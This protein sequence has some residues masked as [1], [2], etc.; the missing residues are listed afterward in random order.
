MAG[1]GS[2]VSG[3]PHPGPSAGGFTPGG[4][5]HPPHHM[6]GHHHMNRR[7]RNA[8]IRPPLS[9]LTKSVISHSILLFFIFL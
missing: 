4:F 5:H 2:H 3:G 1:G 7:G 8:K 6:A 9:V